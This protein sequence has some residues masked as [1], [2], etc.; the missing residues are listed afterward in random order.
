MKV[1]GRSPSR[2]GRIHR[3]I[4]L[5]HREAVGTV[6][7]TDQKTGICFVSFCG[8]ELS[9][10][11]F[12]SN[13]RLRKLVRSRRYSRPRNFVVKFGSPSSVSLV[14]SRTVR[15]FSIT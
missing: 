8:K 12:S 5:A 6:R 10:Y 4:E 7:S 1:T 15:P 13:D 14:P 9:D 2:S 11:E 3:E